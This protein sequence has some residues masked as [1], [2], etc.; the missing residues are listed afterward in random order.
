[1]LCS[2]NHPPPTYG[3]W[4]LAVINWVLFFLALLSPFEFD[5]AGDEIP[6]ANN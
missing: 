4:K 6:S 2:A 1:M 3:W 5:E